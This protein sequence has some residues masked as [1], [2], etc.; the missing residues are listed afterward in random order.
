MLKIP[1][2]L[3]MLRLSVVSYLNTA[4]FRFGISNAQLIP[5][6]EI[7]ISLDIPSICAEKLISGQVDVGLVPV[8]TLPL[9]PH[10]T[11]LG[12]TC[13]GAVGKVDTVVL[14]SQVPLEEI[15]EIVL[16]YQS[17]T[18]VNL[19]RLLSRDYW[20]ISPRFTPAQ[21]DFLDTLKGKR[22]GVLIGDRVFDHAHTFA[23][24][25]DLSEAWMN[26]HHQPFVFACWVAVHPISEEQWA[27]IEKALQSG[28]S[29]I[30][31]AAAS[32]IPHYPNH[33]P[34]ETYLSQRISYTLDAAKRQGL[35]TFLSALSTITSQEIL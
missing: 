24:V 32:V 34:V 23:Y 8:A 1:R 7:S 33:Y 20:K 18:S 26:W 30:E 12:N 35:E 3:A 13:I 4:P 29:N 19:C 31:A 17:R 14:L 10:Y 2:Y 15:E 28:I 16:D 11:I 22:A 6:G 9:L 27:P 25:Y 21:P 5:S